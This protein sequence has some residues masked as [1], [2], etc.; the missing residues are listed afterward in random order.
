MMREALPRGLR[1]NPEGIEIIDGEDGDA[2]S[3][4]STRL[5]AAR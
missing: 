4:E 2:G 3:K 1:M 5:D